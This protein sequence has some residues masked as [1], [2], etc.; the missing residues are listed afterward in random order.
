MKI[1]LDGHHRR[2]E[3]TLKRWEKIA[4][5][6]LDG[7]SVIELAKKYGYSRAYFYIMF[8]KLNERDNQ[9]LDKP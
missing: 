9:V 3:R 2:A 4:K 5:E 1:T 7:K 6:Y 8:K